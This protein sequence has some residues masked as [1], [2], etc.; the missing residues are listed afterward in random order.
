MLNTSVECVWALQAL[1]GV[2]RMPVTLHLKPYIPSAHSDLLVDTDAGKVPLANTA[3]YHSLV[4]AGVIDEHGRVDAAVRDWMTVLGRAEREAVL[5]IRRPDQPATHECPAT[6]H[7][8]TM[9]VCRY[10]RYLAMAARDGDDMVIG[11]VGESDE[12]TRQVELMCQMLVPAFGEH[13]PADIEGINVPKDMMQ[14]AIDAA[15]QTPEGMAAALRR[16]GLGPWEVEV[17]QAA[18]R[19][20][21]SAMAVVAVIDHCPDVRPHPRVLTV[22]DTEY[23]RISFTTTTGA[24]GKEWMSIWPTTASGLR[25]DLANLLSAPQLV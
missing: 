15:G 25:D 3:Q 12:P 5:T 17:V 11:G 19:L 14:M 20:D 23:G 16:L 21:Q 6:V 4:Q 10:G 13:P 9:V 1:L 7:E 24:D 2:E 22:A 8:R 18:S